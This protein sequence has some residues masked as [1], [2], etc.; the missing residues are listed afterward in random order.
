MNDRDDVE[1]IMERFSGKPGPPGLKER[2]LKGAEQKAKARRI[3][4]PLLSAALAGC[5]V[6]LII[7]T[8]ADWQISGT[9]ERRL[10]SF[11]R[12]TPA[13]DMSFKK[14]IDQKMGEF[15]ANVTDVDIITARNLRRSFLAQEKVAKA[16]RPDIRLKEEIYEN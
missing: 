12:L 1:K 7:L 16:R 9:Q 11:L 10:N 15:L 6:L 4:T 14:I 3:M 13:G 5:S 2:V 8:L